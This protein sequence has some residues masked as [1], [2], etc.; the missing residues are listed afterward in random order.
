LNN[1]NNKITLVSCFSIIL[2][3]SALFIIDENNSVVKPKMNAEFQ[4]LL[5]SNKYAFEKATLPNLP[6]IE[7]F[8]KPIP[9]SLEGIDLN[10]ALPLDSDGN[11]IVGM[12]IKDLFE[13]YL[14][15]MGEEELDDILLRI[16]SALAQQLKTPALEQ[17]YDALNRFIGYKVELANLEKQS[18]DNNLSELENIRQQKEILGSIQQEYFSPS[19][20]DALFAAETEYDA[21][22]L[23]HLTIQQNDQLTSA[24]KQQQVE[25]LEAS[26]PEEVRA[27]RESA[28]AP[29]KVYQQAQEMKA[30]GQTAT[31]IYQ[32]RAESLGEE[33][34]SALAQLDQK[35][36]Q[37]Q[38]RL[39]IFNSE[40]ESI[41]TSGL[42]ETDQKTEVNALLARDFDTTET[43]RVRALTGL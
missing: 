20:N 18:L 21:F 15:A 31:A 19:E 30:E 9:K 35:R 4:P 13:L 37:W 16:Q 27:G 43:I 26:L 2:F 1:K 8:A 36:N 12:E 38:Q 41:S 17:G 22:M 5:A 33:A 40:Y 24:E 23:E 6:S 7:S 10:I 3:S 28:M 42:S 29:A 34:A 11:L 25:A 32:M 39:E 14:S